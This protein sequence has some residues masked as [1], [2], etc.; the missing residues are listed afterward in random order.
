MQYIEISIVLPVFNE[1]NTIKKI[2]EKLIDLPLS[3]EVI[4]VNDGST[5][6]T[7]S[8]LKEI[9][10]D[11]SVKIIDHK[12]N[13]GKGAAIRTGIKYA[14]GEFF[15][16]QDGDLEQDPRDIANLLSYAKEK[17]LDAVF[18]SRV[19][20]WGFKYDIRY[21]A[22]MLFALITNL[23]FKAH[24]TD[25]M[26]GYKLCRTGIVKDLKLNSNGFDIEPEITAKLL[27]LNI[28]IHEIPVSYNPRTKKEGKK[29][30]FWDSFKVIGRLLREK[31]IT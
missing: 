14:S 10:K 13:S 16:I 9:K 17:N 20:N 8:I 31:L 22:N 29:I 19:L 4:I 11:D 18:G 30:C 27:K 6:N 26:T 24:L 23:M 25:I 21:V 3:K 15:I 1:E 28:N 5:D 2:T 12:K 7:A